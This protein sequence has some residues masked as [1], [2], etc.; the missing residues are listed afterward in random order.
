M[1]QKAVRGVPWTLV[2]FAGSKLITVA[3]TLALARLLAP[4]DFGVVALA[5]LVV[6]V[7]TLIGD[8]GLAA[9]FVLRQ[10][11]DRRAMGTLLTMVL[12]MGAVVA[13]VGAAISPV[14]ATAFDE[15]RLD[16]VLAVMA[17]SAFLIAPAWFYEAL[18]QRELEFPRRFV[19]QGA[20]A[21]TNA[22][23]ALTIA[24]LGGGVWSIVAGQLSSTVAYG[25]TLMALA[26]YR[27]RPAFDRTRARDLLGTSTGF[28]V[29]TGASFAR[30]NLDYGVVGRVLGSGALGVY[31][32][33]YRL[34]DLTYWAVADPV[35]K[36]TFPAFAR[37]RHRGEDVTGSFLSVLRLVG[38][39]V[40]PLGVVLSAAADPFTRALFDEDWVSMIGPLAA[41]G[42]WAAVRPLDA[43][44]GWL[45]NSVGEARVMGRIA[46]L[47][48]L[49]LLPALIVAAE[50]GGLTALAWV[51]LA[52]RV[53][54]LVIVT[55]LASRRAGVPVSAT[56]RALRPV[57][58]AAPVAWLATRGVAEV[59]SGAPPLVALVVAALAGAGAFAAAVTVAA[60][61]VIPDAV[62]QAARTIG[63]ERESRES[64]ASVSPAEPRPVEHA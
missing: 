59:L 63:R 4:E 47:M 13:A 43:T 37:A 53:A 29:Q 57:V 20:Q 11:L 31:S 28:L 35:A 55:N 61:G 34:C 10:D 3:T 17:A 38:L 9:T 23:V 6:G 50:L 42:L 18:L 39:V 40:V 36:V 46:A 52:D 48:L 2:G 51:V 22:A 26:P 56:W 33:A 25:A 49:P 14:M 41:L 58:L 15:Q 24:A 62:R 19:G 64:A 8:L 5:T 60:P 7:L 21:L 16:E 45:L 12:T 54:A 32:V 27:V 1:E 44:V 30:E